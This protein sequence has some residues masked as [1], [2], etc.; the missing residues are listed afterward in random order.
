MNAAKVVRWNDVERE[1]LTPLI[2]RQYISLNSVTLARFHLKKGAVVP[3]HHHVNE[4]M[5]YVVEG[6]LHFVMPDKEVTVRA[7]EVLCIPAELP[8]AA[9]A[10]EDCYVIDLF[11]PHRKDWADKQDGYLRGK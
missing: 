8:H 5:S 6:A 10:K 11:M 4:Q 2:D 3:E 7:G 1:Q 9:E